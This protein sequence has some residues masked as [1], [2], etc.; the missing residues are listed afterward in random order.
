VSPPPFPVLFRPA[1][2]GDLGYIVHSWLESFHAGNPQMR[3]VRMGRF[4][5]P[6]RRA[7]HTLLATS[8][9]VMACDPEQPSHLYGFIAAEMVG[10]SPVVHY[11]YVSQL[12]RS[13]GLARGLAAEALRSMGGSAWSEF[14]H[15]TYV[16]GKIAER[17][18]IEFNPFAAAP[19]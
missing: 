2:P 5:N 7:I 4:K 12:R 3:L 8:T 6:M 9:V 13:V 19:K 15:L 10:V 18:G 17:Q 11:C 14:T 16:G 1:E